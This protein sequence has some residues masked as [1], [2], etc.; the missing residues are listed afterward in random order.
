[1]SVARTPSL[2]DLMGSAQ[3]AEVRA[4]ACAMS[5]RVLASSS[6]G[7]CTLVTVTGDGSSASFLVDAG[8][9]PRRTRRLLEEVGMSLAD[10]RGVVY[11]HL[12]SDHC[13]AGWASALPGAA[14]VRMHAQHARRARDTGLH[15]RRPEYF[16]GPFEV[17]PGVRA[18]PVLMA[19][20][21][22]GVAAFRFESASSSLGYATDCG[23]VTRGLVDTLADVDT[24][25]IESNYCPEMQAASA[26]PEALKRRIMGGSGHLSNQECAKAVR[27]IK[28][29]RHV[30]LLHLSRQCNTPERAS[31]L[32]DGAPYRLTVAMHDRATDEIRVGA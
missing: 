4:P 23:R 10:I 2:W 5:I 30:V 20:D 27:H 3:A 16:D 6:S 18:T 17:V 29:R 13:H 22:L 28:P 9:S 15:E 25:A 32:H 12:D 14:W 26:R 11:T 7:N 8:L 24:L 1:M 19:H 21:G 31:S